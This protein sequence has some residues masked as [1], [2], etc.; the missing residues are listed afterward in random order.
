[1]S[2]KTF[3]DDIIESKV[4]FFIDTHTQSHPGDSGIGGNLPQDPTWE[5]SCE[6]VDVVDLLRRNMKEIAD[7]V[8]I[9]EG[10]NY[11]YKQI[12]LYSKIMQFSHAMNETIGEKHD[13]C[14]RLEDLERF[15]VGRS[16]EK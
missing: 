10:H 16:I 9:E 3:I 12:D 7:L 14:I 8:E 13:Y 5:F 11:I 1:M 2:T 6:P 4:K 15:M